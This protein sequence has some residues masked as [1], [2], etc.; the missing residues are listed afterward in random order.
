M[1]GACVRAFVCV[2]VCVCV[3]EALRKVL[4]PFFLAVWH[5]VK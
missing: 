1:M 2:N 5:A 3:S 4:L